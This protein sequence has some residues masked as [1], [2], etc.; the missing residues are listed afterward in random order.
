MKKKLF[1]L[2]MAVVIL[3]CLCG[4]ASAAAWDAYLLQDQADLLTASQT[5]SITRILEDLSQTYSVPVALVITDD[6]PSMGPDRYGET[7][8]DNIV[9]LSSDCEGGVLL[10]VCMDLREFRII[11][12]GIADEALSDWDVQE[13]TDEIAPLLSE[14]EYVAAV[15]TYAGICRGCLDEHYHFN[16]GKHLLIACVIGLIIGLIVVFILKGQLKSVRQ[17][18]QANAYIKPGSLQITGYS[19]LYLYRTVSRVRKENNSSS[20]SRGSS[21]GS[22]SRGGGRF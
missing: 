6:T 7:C 12:N 4:T 8:L 19:D 14:G 15:E 17:Q 20:G 18:N 11:T 16:V 22:H 1:S 5:R 13:I 10:L 21:G 2:L 9:T 3:L